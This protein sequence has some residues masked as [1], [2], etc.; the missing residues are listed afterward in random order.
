MVESGLTETTIYVHLLLSGAEYVELV[1]VLPNHVV[2]YT[3]MVIRY[4]DYFSLP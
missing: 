4:F 3:T 2:W 1:L